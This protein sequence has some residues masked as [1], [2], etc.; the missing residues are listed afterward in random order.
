MCSM[1]CL[2]M[3][4]FYF[5][6]TQTYSIKWWWNSSIFYLLLLER[7]VQLHL[8]LL[9]LAMPLTKYHDWFFILPLVRQLKFYI[10]ITHMDSGGGSW[11][12]Y[13]GHTLESPSM[14]LEMGGLIWKFYFD[15]FIVHLDINYILLLCL[16]CIICVNIAPKVFAFMHKPSTQ[17]PPLWISGVD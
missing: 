12:V 10:I 14:T 11:W 16:F 7:G 2:T 4:W 5:S 17:V 1:K 15:C 3:A 9:L 13:L 8:F 6:H